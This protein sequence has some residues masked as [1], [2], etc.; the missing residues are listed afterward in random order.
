MGGLDDEK[1]AKEK[2]KAL[3][4]SHC[5]KPGHT[6]NYCWDLHLE[7]M[8]AKFRKS[9]SETE[10]KKEQP[11]VKAA[12]AKPGDGGGHTCRGPCTPCRR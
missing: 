2:L 6:A 1:L 7:L 11:E 8:L 9:E 10:K 12:V 4:C 3:L 5:G